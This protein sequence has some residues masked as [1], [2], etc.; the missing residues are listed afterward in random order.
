M[1]L[2]EKKIIKQQQPLP[3]LY[4]YSVSAFVLWGIFQTAMV[5]FKDDSQLTLSR[6]MFR[7]SLLLCMEAYV[8]YRSFL[9]YT[10]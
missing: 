7:L 2:I 5:F 10:K 4:F 9:S 3:K 8:F 6:F 1:S